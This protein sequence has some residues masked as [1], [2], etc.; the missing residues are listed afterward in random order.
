MLSL[1][2]D[3]SFYSQPEYL[4]AVSHLSVNSRNCVYLHSQWGLSQLLES[5]EFPPFILPLYHCS[6]RDRD[7]TLHNNCYSEDSCI[8][9][10]LT[11]AQA[12]TASLT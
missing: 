6:D 2:D 10:G 5:M 3:Q 4:P 8:M 9:L 1:A 11:S 12:Y 7:T